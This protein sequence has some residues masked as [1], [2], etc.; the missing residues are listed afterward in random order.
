MVFAALI[1]EQKDSKSLLF[2]D[3]FFFSQAEKCTLESIVLGKVW[4]AGLPPVA[5]DGHKKKINCGLTLMQGQ[6]NRGNEKDTF[7]VFKKFFFSTS[8]LKSKHVLTI[9][10][11]IFKKKI[12]VFGAQQQKG[13][14]H[15]QKGW[16]ERF[17]IAGACSQDKGKSLV[18]GELV[19]SGCLRCNWAEKTGVWQREEA[20]LRETKNISLSSCG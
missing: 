11:K 3:F 1:L 4:G 8:T 15:G 16:Q 12:K 17:P 9:I 2:P 5:W 14:S 19:G 7:S 10:G 6:V 18:E 13:Q 20:R